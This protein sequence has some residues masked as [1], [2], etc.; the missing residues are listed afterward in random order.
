MKSQVNEEVVKYI[1]FENV[2]QIYQI[3]ININENFNDDNYTRHDI[4]LVS[5]NLC[6]VNYIN[7]EDRSK[8]DTYMFDIYN[9]DINFSTIMSRKRYIN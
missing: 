2:T 5:C 7:Y 4:T 1:N 9:I 8:L 6:H 3:K